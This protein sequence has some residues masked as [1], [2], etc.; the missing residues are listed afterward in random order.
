MNIVFVC[1]ENSNRSQMAEAFAKMYAP[2]EYQIFSAG[3]AASGVINPKAIKAMEEIN[4]NLNTHRSQ[5]IEDLPIQEAD[6]VISMGCG[7][8]CPNF[9]ARFRFEWNFPD[10]KHLNQAEY[11]LIRDQIKINVLDFFTSIS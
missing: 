4:Y 2:K 10:P 1:T 5:S 6:Y 3:S 8:M 11:N 7:D 9:P